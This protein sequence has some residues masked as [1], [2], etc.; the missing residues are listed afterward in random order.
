V[1]GYIFAKP[2]EPERVAAYISDFCPQKSARTNG[3]AVAS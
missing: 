3:Y 1:Q 2:L